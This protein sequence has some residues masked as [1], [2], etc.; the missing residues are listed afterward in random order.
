MKA[1]RRVLQETANYKCEQFEK[2]VYTVL[3]GVGEPEIYLSFDGSLSCHDHAERWSIITEDLAE[4]LK[5][6]FDLD[7]LE[8]ATQ[9]L[10]NASESDIACQLQLCHGDRDKQIG[11][12]LDSITDDPCKDDRAHIGTACATCDVCTG[13]EV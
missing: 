2:R 3:D 8:R 10:D 6:Q 4:S 5:A 9:I 11:C 12:I 7:R 13:K 1:L